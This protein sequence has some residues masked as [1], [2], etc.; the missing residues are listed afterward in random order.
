MGW[1]SDSVSY[2]VA[3]NAWSKGNGTI[4][5]NTGNFPTYPNGAWQNCPLTN[6]GA[7]YGYLYNARNGHCNFD[8]VND[9][10]ETAHTF[11]WD[12]ST[13]RTFEFK[14]NFI[15]N[16]DYQILGG[17]YHSSNNWAFLCFIFPD[18]TIGFYFYSTAGFQ[19]ALTT[20]KV[21]NGD[22]T[23]HFVKDGSA[24]KIYLD[25]VECSYAAQDTYNYS[26]HN[27]FASFV[28]GN[29]H[30]TVY[31]WNGKIYWAAVYDKVLSEAT[32]AEHH[33]LAND[34]GLIGSNDGDT[35][36]LTAQEGSMFFDIKGGIILPMFF[37]IRDSFGASTFW[38]TFTM[39]ASGEKVAFIFRAPKTGTIDKIGFLVRAVTSSQSLD[40]RL[41]TVNATTGDP[42]G[43]LIAAGASGVVASPAA[44]TFYEVTLTTPPSVTVNDYIAVVIQFTST[45]G[46]LQIAA[47]DTQTSTGDYAQLPYCDHY[48]TSWAKQKFIPICSVRYNDTTYPVNGMLPL[49]NQSEIGLNTGST[50]DEVGMKFQLPIRTKI[51]GLWLFTYLRYPLTLKLYDENDSLV[52]SVTLD[53]DITSDSAAGWQLWFFNSSI[54]LSKNKTYRIT[55]LPTTASDIFVQYIET[56]LNSM[57]TQLTA[58]EN[59]IWTQRTNA[60]AWTDTNTRRPYWGLILDSLEYITG[61]TN[62]FNQKFN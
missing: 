43:T 46:N 28:V 45:V 53:P 16:N 7:G 6:M 54:I 26:L 19:R 35:M 20:T 11:Q 59:F 18:E 2:V 8:A 62:I 37:P 14:A 39:D 44:N 52:D 42:T 27:D 25:G 55:V 40:V 36:Y 31:A 12:V 4:D 34:M 29:D 9:K 56:N 21:T 22:H 3:P 50:P 5:K 13:K 24:I 61:V 33:S 1:D 17:S 38:K 10:I 57:L 47:W 23:F 58:D 41:E 30:R 48:T 60:G 49:K 32:M 51:K 15:D